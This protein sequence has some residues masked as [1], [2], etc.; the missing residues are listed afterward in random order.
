MTFPKR[1]MG[2]T[3]SQKCDFGSE[4]QAGG[5]HEHFRVP[6]M[7]HCL[8]HSLFRYEAP[9]PPTELDLPPKTSS[10]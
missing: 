7:K 3:L 2:I 4:D 6:A 8:P 5:I 1:S 10:G 9:Q